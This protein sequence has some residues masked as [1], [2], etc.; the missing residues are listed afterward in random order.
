MVRVKLMKNTVSWTPQKD[1]DL[2]HKFMGSMKD[3]TDEED[4]AA[5]VDSPPK[6]DENTPSYAGFIASDV[7]PDPETEKEAPAVIPS[8]VVSPEQETSK[9][10]DA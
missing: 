6:V 8:V 10:S 4:L 3:L 9:I 5:T 2:Y 7:P 1:I